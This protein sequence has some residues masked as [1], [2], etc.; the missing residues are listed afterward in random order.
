MIE[1]IE[2]R[3]EDH[4]ERR[5]KYL[6]QQDDL[7]EQLRK[8]EEKDRE[9]QMKR[10]VSLQIEE[11]MINHVMGQIRKKSDYLHSYLDKKARDEKLR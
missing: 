10:Q 5:K 6:M 2:K 8:R 11:S 4:Q 7:M 9:R 1:N 3:I